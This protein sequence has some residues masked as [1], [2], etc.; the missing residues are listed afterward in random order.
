MQISSYDPPIFY[1]YCEKP[2]T[3]KQY[4][5]I[6]ARWTAP[7]SESLTWPCWR[8]SWVRARRCAVGARSRISIVQKNY[9]DSF[10]GLVS[11]NCYPYNLD[12]KSTTLNQKA[13][14]RGGKR[15][16]PD[17]ARTAWSCMSLATFGTFK[18]LCFS[19][20]IIHMNERSES[21]RTFKHI[22]DHFRY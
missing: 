1:P 11:S 3:C 13:C 2:L 15:T 20:N 18:F 16:S 7:I 10:F 14:R 4:A 6:P 19:H 12:N 17:L 22:S 8:E 9:S 21:F 5:V